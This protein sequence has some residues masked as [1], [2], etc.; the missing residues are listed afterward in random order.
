MVELSCFVTFKKLLPFF[1]TVIWKLIWT[2]IWISVFLSQLT[3]LRFI[4]RFIK[5]TIKI[6]YQIV[7]RKSR[8]PYPYCILW[9][10]LIIPAKQKSTVV[11]TQIPSLLHFHD[12]QLFNNI[13]QKGAMKN[14][15]QTVFGNIGLN[16]ESELNPAYALLT[17]SQQKKLRRI[18]LDRFSVI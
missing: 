13:E 12:K 2:Y 14:Q 6:C 17:N 15:I 1:L 18:K 9:T 7:F 4:L 16:R 11:G 8:K 10:S 5:S 3:F